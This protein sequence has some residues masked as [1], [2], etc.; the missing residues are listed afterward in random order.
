MFTAEDME[1]K[2]DKLNHCEGIDV[3][4]ET[5]LYNKFVRFGKVVTLSTSELN[6]LGWSKSGFTLEMR[7]RGFSVV[8]RSDQRDGD[9]YEITFPPQG[10]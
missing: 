4:I 6:K 9:Y 5:D 2:L 8:Y 1:T 10:R 3:W 7:I